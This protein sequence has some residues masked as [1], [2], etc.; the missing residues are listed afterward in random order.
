MVQGEEYLCLKFIMTDFKGQREKQREVALTIPVQ[1][2]CNPSSMEEG[3]LP[4]PT[5][6]PVVC[7]GLKQT[8]RLRNWCL[9]MTCGPYPFLLLE[10]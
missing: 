7:F 1:G 10:V 3:Q 6:A 4:Y 5:L 8:T 2:A 9:K